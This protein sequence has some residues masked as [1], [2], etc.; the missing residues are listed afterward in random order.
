MIA[1]HEMSPTNFILALFEIEENM[2]VSGFFCYS[3]ANQG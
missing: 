1:R 2:Y 3:R